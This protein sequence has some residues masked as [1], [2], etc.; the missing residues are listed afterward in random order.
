MSSTDHD[1]L[2]CLPL[3][4]VLMA[5]FG[6]E[7]SQRSRQHYRARQFRLPDRSATIGVTGR[8]WFDNG[9]GHGGQGAIDL[10]LHLRGCT[11]GQAAD[12]LRRM[13]GLP[14]LFLPGNPERQ[15]ASQPARVAEAEPPPLPDECAWPAGAAYLRHRGISAEVL[16]RVHAAGQ[17]Y[18][19]RSGRHVNVVF[20]L[21]G[22]GAFARGTG[23]SFKRFYGGTGVW[24]LPGDRKEA[25]IAVAESPIDTLA[26]LSLRAEDAA[27]PDLLAA[28]GNAAFAQLAGAVEARAVAAGWPLKEVT[29]YG[30]FDRDAAGARFLCELQRQLAGRV[31]TVVN[32]RPPAPAKDWAE[33]AARI[34]LSG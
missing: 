6:A 20:P 12:E 10:V 26:W 4:E 9:T 1:A 28:G 2:R 22:G 3:P 29:V 27:W 18:A 13:A 30:L 5:L 25:L 11:F 16:A 19:A 31:R 8:M 17:V 34:A 7:E 33:H 24:V 21:P 15:S 14:I 32:L 23:G